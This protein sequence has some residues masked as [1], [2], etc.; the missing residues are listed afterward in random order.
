VAFLFFTLLFNIEEIVAAIKRTKVSLMISRLEM[1][2]VSKPTNPKSIISN[3]KPSVNL[4][5]VVSF[6]KKACPRNIPLI[7]KYK[8]EVAIPKTWD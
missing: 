3:R 2:M 4:K 6:S 5:K 8:T 1:I 7:K